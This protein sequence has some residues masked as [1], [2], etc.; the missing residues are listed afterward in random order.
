MLR[1]LIFRLLTDID[2]ASAVLVHGLQHPD[3]IIS[4]RVNY[5]GEVETA[6]AALRT[7]DDEE[8]GEAAAMQAEERSGPFGLPLFLQ[9]AAPAAPDPIEGGGTHPLESGRIN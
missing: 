8:V 5:V 2:D 4:V 6:A 3:D 7:S 1:I 9:G